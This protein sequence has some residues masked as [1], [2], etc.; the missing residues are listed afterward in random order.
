MRCE[1]VGNTTYQCFESERKN[2]FC[3]LCRKQKVKRISSIHWKFVTTH[4]LII[5]N[6]LLNIYFKNEYNLGKVDM[7]IS[8]KNTIL[9]LFL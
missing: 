8:C 7:K 1:K 4:I 9:F 3:K 6:L 5:L 2:V